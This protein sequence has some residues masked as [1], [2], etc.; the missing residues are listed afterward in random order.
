MRK[1]VVASL[2]FLGSVCLLQLRD[3]FAADKLGYVDLTK[4]FTEYQKTKDYDKV[5]TQKEESFN[6]EREKKLAEIKQLQDKLNLLSEKEKEAKKGELDAKTKDLQEFDRQK[7]MDLRKEHDEKMKEILQ[8]IDEAIKEV[9]KKE[10]YSFIFNDRFL[11]YQA[12]EFD[13]TDK[14]MSVLAT[15]A[16]SAQSATKKK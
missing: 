3:C 10:D 7:T 8:D 6:A 15:K 5:L 4:V 11:L 9:A 2:V 14:V 16:A 1:I 12:K 13:L